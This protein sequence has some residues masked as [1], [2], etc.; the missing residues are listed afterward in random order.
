MKTFVSVEEYKDLEELIMN[1]PDRKIRGFFM[2]DAEAQFELDYCENCDTPTIVVTNSHSLC[3]RC[4][5]DH[6]LD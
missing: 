4:R 3:P 6:T 2:Y 5:A 1:Y